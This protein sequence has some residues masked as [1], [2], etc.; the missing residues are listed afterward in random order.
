MKRFLAIAGLTVLAGASGCKLQSPG[1]SS[2]D[3]LRVQLT[4]EPVT[5]DPSLAE[6]GSAL[7]VLAQTHEGLVGYDG[8]SHLVLRL[9][10]SYEKS[11]D[12]RQWRFKLK[13]DLKWSDGSPLTAEDFVTG[14][15]RSLDPKTGSKLSQHLS[16][17]THVLAPAADRL[18]LRLNAPIPHLLQALTLPVA[19]PQKAGRPS[20]GAGPYRELKQVRSGGLLRMELERNPFYWGPKAA[21]ERATWLVVPDENTGMNL[22]A[23]GQL[24]VLMKVPATDLDHLQREGRLVREPFFAT[25]FLGFNCRKAPFSDFHERRAL[26][27]AVRRQDIVRALGTGE[28]ASGSW[29]PWTLEGALDGLGEPGVF[30][31]DV[32]AAAKRPPHRDLVLGFD[33]GSRNSTVAER[34]QSDVRAALGWKLRLEHRDWKSY[35]ARVRSDPPAIYR[36]GWQAPFFDP[37]S[38][39]DAWVSTSPNATSGCK[40]PRYDAWVEKIRALDP[41]PERKALLEKAQ[42]FLVEEA[43]WVVPLFSY[44]SNIAVSSRVRQL[45]INNFGVIRFDEL[46]F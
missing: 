30:E 3:E 4:S 20:L 34:V 38:H 36:F 31:Q 12:G 18:E 41:G 35:V 21:V 13:P 37:L 16:G 29:I 8:G 40:D 11:R 5:L 46:T 7:K 39:L 19:V 25:Y 24:D 23:S 22:F 45:R 6:D 26:A 42:R 2:A 1:Q 9:A 14:L 43:A 27:G 33:S 10:Q 28:R 32:K 17:I 15:R 44:V